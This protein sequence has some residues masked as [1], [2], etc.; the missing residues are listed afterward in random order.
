M[1]LRTKLLLAQSPLAIAMVI[2]GLIALRS[3]AELG[4]RSPG[5]S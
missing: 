2:L 1:S 4:R 3:N 5:R